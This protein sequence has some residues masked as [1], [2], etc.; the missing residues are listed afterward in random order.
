[1]TRRIA[2]GEIW[3][4][5]LEPPLG[6]GPGYRRPVV[7]VQSDP[8]NASRIATVIV[9]ALTTN[10]DLAKAPGNLLLR[11]RT[12]GMS[13]DSVI[14]VSQLL[15]IDRALLGVRIGRLPAAVVEALDDGLRLVLGL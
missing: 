10:L 4:A 13:R 15:T 8:F 1:M 5:E 14:N 12:A 7:V 6:S 2:R 9:A 3:W 11:R